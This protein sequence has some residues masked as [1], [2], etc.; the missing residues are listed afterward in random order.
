MS[1]WVKFGVECQ[2][3]GE[4][5]GNCGHHRVGAKTKVPRV[6]C[7]AAS[8]NRND[9][10]GVDLGV[11]NVGP[12]KPRVNFPFVGKSLEGLRE[13]GPNMAWLC[14]PASIKNERLL[15]INVW[16]ASN[17]VALVAPKVEATTT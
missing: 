15:P 1:N 14:G 12:G 11:P 5:P 4:S 6:L 16:V 8:T 7:F 10:I 9:G 2:F 13:S 3:Q 17:R